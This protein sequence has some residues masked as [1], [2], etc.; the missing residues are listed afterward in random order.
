MLAITLL[1]SLV[2]GANGLQ[3]SRLNCKCHI[4][5]RGTKMSSSNCLGNWTCAVDRILFGVCN[6]YAM[7]ASNG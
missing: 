5:I 4:S 6:K 1:F 2:P 3:Y 7:H